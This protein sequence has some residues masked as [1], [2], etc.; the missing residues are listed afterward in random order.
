M[1]RF[2]LAILMLLTATGG[3]GCATMSRPPASNPFFVAANDEEAVWER[4]VDV[5]H[6]YFEIE[7]ENKLDG[8]IETQPK[9]GASLFEPWHHD[10]QGF[11]NRLESTFQSIRRRAF[12]NV[13]PTDGGYLVGVE[14][15]KEL[16]D[17]PGIAANTPGAAT[18]Q[19]NNPLRRDLNLVVGQSTPSGWLILGRDEVLERDMLNSLQHEFSR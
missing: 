9:V 5:I 4:T 17:L 13:T 16:E 12:V 14:V 11:D 19:Q 6:N 18:F 10:S 1:P 3:T 7:R 8:V 2:L 15:I